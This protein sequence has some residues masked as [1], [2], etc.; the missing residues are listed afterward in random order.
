M[1]D[2]GI[3]KRIE[4]LVDALSAG[5]YERREHAAVV[6]LAAL[7]GQN[8]F[9]LGPPGTAK[10]L[11]ARRL[12]SLFAGCG[13]YF[14]YLMQRFSTP[15]DIFGPVSIKALKEDKYERKT[16]G[17]LPSAHFAFLDEIW[18]SGPAI[19]NTLLTI[20]NE[21]KFRNGAEVKNVDL[22]SLIAASN[23]TPPKG[24]GLEALYDRFIVRLYAPPIKAV[25]NFDAFLHADAVSDSV[26]C[27]DIVIRPHEWKKWREGMRKVELS[28]E[29]MQIIRAIRMKLA[30]KQNELKTSVSDRRWKKAADFL[31]A[32]AFFCGRQKTN[33]ADTLLLRHCLW[34]DDKTREAVIDIVENAVRECGFTTD[35]STATIVVEKEKLDKD[36]NRELLYAEDVYK[37]ETL[38]DKKEY[39]YAQVEHNHIGNMTD[40]YVPVEKMKSGAEFHPVDENGQEIDRFLC[41][42][43]KQGSFAVKAV[44]GRIKTIRSDY[45]DEVVIKP[46][47]SIPKDAR[48]NKSDVNP[49]LIRDFKLEVLDIKDKISNILSD[50]TK[51]KSAFQADMD[52]PF[53]PEQSRKIALEAIKAQLQKVRQEHADCDRLLDIIS[54]YE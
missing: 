53:V 10:S 18:K 7:S 47:V 51:Q 29:T 45:K 26:D 28:A 31:R 30:K 48:K 4:K 52:T 5:L 39:F 19:L 8:T 50:I 22:E 20:I 12:A 33:L 43:R 17:F 49:R 46:K 23:E 1:S 2:N 13:Q 21:K 27:G 34:T 32:G 41:T 35:L 38:R 44:R 3:K 36:I 25:E 15:E 42:F 54:E 24:Q 11:L 9:L 40:C 37:T 6:L 14:E 16:E